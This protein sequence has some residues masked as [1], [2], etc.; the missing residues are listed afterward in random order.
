MPKEIICDV[1]NCVYNESRK[2]TRKNIRVLTNTPEATGN[3]AISCMSFR[4]EQSEE[5]NQKP[6]L[7]KANK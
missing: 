3:E 5:A 4:A 2:C 7:A 1:K 6:E